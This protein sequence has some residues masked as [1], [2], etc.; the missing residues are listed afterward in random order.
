ME[1]EGEEGALA[2]KLNEIGIKMWRP[3][4]RHLLLE[5]DQETLANQQV[6]ATVASLLQLPA[7][8]LIL[9]IREALLREELSS[10]ETQ[11]KSRNEA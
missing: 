5:I 2:G 8:L 11:I 6:M 9:R 7:D 4:G 3:F 10:I 1:A